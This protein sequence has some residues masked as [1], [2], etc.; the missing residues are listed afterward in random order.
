MDKEQLRMIE[1]IMNSKLSI[2]KRMDTPQKEYRS[3]ALMQIFILLNLLTA[4]YCVYQAII[5]I[6]NIEAENANWHSFSIAML[7]VTSFACLLSSPKGFADFLLK[8][9]MMKIIKDKPVYN[10]E[11][12]AKLKSTIGKIKDRKANLQYLFLPILLMI[13][14]LLHTLK[15]NPIWNTFAYIAPLSLIMV[16]LILVRNYRIIKTSTIKNERK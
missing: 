16:I 8:R 3:S 14:A 2:A 11:S 13:G 6:I 9:H 4:L 10:E 5:L 15:L 12:N 7:T 1:L